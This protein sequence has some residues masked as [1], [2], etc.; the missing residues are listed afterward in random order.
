[1]GRNKRKTAKTKKPPAGQVA[2]PHVQLKGQLLG[3]MHT[4]AE[5]AVQT[6]YLYVSHNIDILDPLSDVSSTE[7]SRSSSGME[8]ENEF[9]AQIIRR[10]TGQLPESC[11]EDEPTAEGSS[12][13]DWSTGSDRSELNLTDNDLRDAVMHELMH[14]CGRQLVKLIQACLSDE[15]ATPDVLGNLPAPLREALRKNTEYATFM[16]ANGR[17]KEYKQTLADVTM[18]D[19]LDFRPVYLGMTVSKLL[20][21]AEERRDSS[22]ASES[23]DSQTPPQPCQCEVCSKWPTLRSDFGAL[24]GSNSVLCRIFRDALETLKVPDRGP[25]EDEPSLVLDHRNNPDPRA[26]ASSE[27]EP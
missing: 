21:R 22:G 11:S 9:Y 4:L 3:G 2:D 15:M 5:Q 8:E 1:M 23:G 18:Q 19:D 6:A 16:V 26:A 20:R 25:E 13:S 7:D 12:A 10:E 27:D 24:R 14:G 17:Q